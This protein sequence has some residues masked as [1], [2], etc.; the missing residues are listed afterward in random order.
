VYFILIVI[1]VSFSSLLSQILYF[2]IITRYDKNCLSTSED[3]SVS[4]FNLK[5]LKHGCHHISS[6]TLDNFYMLT[7]GSR[8]HC[9]TYISGFTVETYSLYFPQPLVK[10]QW[11]VAE[12][13]LY[14]D[15]G[16]RFVR[17]VNRMVLSYSN[18]FC[19]MNSSVSRHII[20]RLG[21]DIP[22]SLCSL[23][24]S[25]PVWNMKVR[26]GGH[27]IILLPVRLDLSS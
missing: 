18:T 13:L 5:W 25:S 16:Q 3:I 14:S 8:S 20:P 26:T 23:I 19:R 17:L 2:A 9:S 11:H 4:V 27:K 22:L 21:S 10:Y 12:Y 1:A 24:F 6:F 7:G 15:T